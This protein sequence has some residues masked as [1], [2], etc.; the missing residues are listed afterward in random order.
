MLTIVSLLVP[1]IVRNLVSRV[2]VVSATRDAFRCFG[3]SRAGQMPAVSRAAFSIHALRG[4]TLGLSPVDAVAAVEASPVAD[5][6]FRPVEPW[7][8]RLTSRGKF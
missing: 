4:R 3:N 8:I 5:Y 1:L 2:T 6:R 7:Q